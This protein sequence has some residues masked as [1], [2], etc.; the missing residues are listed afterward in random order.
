MFKKLRNE[1]WKEFGKE[2]RFTK[3][4]AISNHGRLLSFDKKIEDGILLKGSIADGYKIFRFSVIEN[5]ITVPKIF[6]VRKLVAQK[7]LKKPTSKQIYVLLLDNNRSNNSVKNLK[8]ATKEEM[9]LHREKSPLVIEGRKR[10]KETRK[11]AKRGPKL[12]V[13]TVKLIKKRIESPN[14]RA[15]MK[16]IAKQYGISEMQLY[17]IKSGENW[18]HISA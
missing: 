2:Y 3:R 10:A 5:G 13:Q 9:I 17:R 11:L 7:F 16:D 18:S 8:W 1:E 4:Y 12:S 15:T 14:R 6:F